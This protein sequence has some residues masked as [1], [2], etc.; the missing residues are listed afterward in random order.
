MILTF[1]P[2]YQRFLKR[3]R[4]QI[5]RDKHALGHAQ[6]QNYKYRYNQRLV[7]R[8]ATQKVTQYIMCNT[9]N[10]LV[11]ISTLKTNES[12][13]NIETVTAAS[14]TQYA[15]YK[16]MTYLLNTR[17]AQKVVLNLNDLKIKKRF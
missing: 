6:I 10:G 3:H 8:E 2:D 11:C 4:L 7:S 13:E 12:L 16:L 14:I 9:S 5:H 15:L 17:R 1:R